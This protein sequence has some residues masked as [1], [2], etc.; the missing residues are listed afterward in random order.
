M[1]TSPSYFGNY[2][3]K[4]QP[5]L[6][7]VAGYIAD[8]R[9]LLQDL[10]PGYRF[11]D[12]SLLVALNV[13]MLEASR[14]RGDLFVFNVLTKGQVQAFQAVDDTYVD[15]EPQFR[16]GI[17]YMLIGHALLREQEDTQVALATSYMNLGD[18]VLIGRMMPPVMGGSGPGGQR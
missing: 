6:N 10:V 7:T 14:K 16:L 9:T 8:A 3:D 4:N 18:A 15:I 11:P 2:E 13:A 5:T 17:L 1:A 12:L